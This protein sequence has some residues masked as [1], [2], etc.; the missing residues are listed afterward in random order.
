M[1]TFIEFAKHTLLELALLE[2]AIILFC[3]CCCCR[4]TVAVEGLWS[5][6]QKRTAYTDYLVSTHQRFQDAQRQVAALQAA[7]DR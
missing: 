7:V 3:C 4:V 6:H 5:D 1:Y 2:L